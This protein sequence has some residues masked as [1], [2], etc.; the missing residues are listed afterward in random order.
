[1]RNEATIRTFF[2]PVSRRGAV[3]AASLAFGLLGAT[4]CGRRA[5]AD[6][7]FQT[8]V[9]R[10]RA[11]H[12]R[13]AIALL[14]RADERQPGD[15]TVLCNL[16]LAYAAQNR[17]DRAVHYLRR[18]ADQAPADPRPLE[19]LG[20]FHLR[21]RRFEA[22]RQVLADAQARDPI[23]PRIPTARALVE[24]EAGEFPR[25]LVR[26][27]EALGRDP[28]YPPALYNKG[29]L[30]RGNPR[31][32]QAAVSAL[33]RFLEVVG[34]T[35]PANADLARRVETAQRHLRTLTAVDPE[36]NL[37]SDP[38]ADTLPAAE[39][40]PAPAAAAPSVSETARV[41]GT[42]TA[43]PL[44]A[45]A[46]LRKAEQA[47]AERALDAAL[48]HLL[49]ATAEYPDSADAMWALV[50]F[51]D[52]QRPAY[53]DEARE[54]YTVFRRRFPEDPRR[55]ALPSRP[56]PSRPEPSRPEP[57]RP[58]PPRPEP[59]PPEPTRIEPSPV[60]DE[61]ADR[62]AAMN[63]WGQGMER[64]R[65]EDWAGAANYYR[66]AVQ[67]N[68][69][70]F[71][72]W[73]N[74]GV[75]LHRIGDMAGAQSALQ[76]ALAIEA[77]R[78]DTQY[79]LAVVLHARGQAAAALQALQ[80]T[81]RLEPDHAQAHYLAGLLYSREPQRNVA[82]ARAHFRR[83]LRREPHGAAAQGVRKWLRDHVEQR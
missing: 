58:E 13:E 4:G 80:R 43:P 18:A 27:E 1:V 28:D 50:N 7:D 3:W 68:P 36:F 2:A 53:A 82:A 42:E 67:Y 16:G 40:D 22:A 8:G 70:L 75:V 54:T 72:A 69:D 5:P 76:N 63:L 11:G 35:D 19:I 24:F 60:R 46:L 83:Y 55:L 17:D 38:E 34:D 66:Q 12:V 9:E 45:A 14:E 61:E 44:S 79:M 81:L 57:S 77:D 41:P 74:L 71:S 51:Y 26:L 56:E 52:G 49:Q 20:Y 10:L 25:A 73:N 47:L 30:C 64:H 6:T 48:V 59:P 15:A 39:S 65:R 32:R 78:A 21:R 62:Q 37:E 33:R 31:T 29:L 23:S